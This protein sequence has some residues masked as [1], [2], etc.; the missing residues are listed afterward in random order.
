MKLTESRLRKIIREQLVL[1][2]RQQ[3]IIQNVFDSLE[4]MAGVSPRFK[5]E[6]VIEAGGH[7]IRFLDESP[8]HLAVEISGPGLF[9]DF[10]FDLTSRMDT[11]SAIVDK[12]QPFI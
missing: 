9:R 2:Q 1:E 7:E 8:I 5:S 10:Q 3:K 4:A 12:V 6:T 11:A